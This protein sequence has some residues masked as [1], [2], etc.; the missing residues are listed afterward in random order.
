MRTY[1][2]RLQ[3]QEIILIT[4]A[5]IYIMEQDSNVYLVRLFRLLREAARSFGMEEPVTD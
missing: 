2:L 1:S 5:E 4:A 3:P